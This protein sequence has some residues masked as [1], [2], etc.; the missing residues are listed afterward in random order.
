M[1]LKYTL[2]GKLDVWNDHGSMTLTPV[3][4]P[5]AFFA[6]EDARGEFVIVWIDT[7]EFNASRE[8]FQSSTRLWE[9]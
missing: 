3:R 5:G 8:K 7:E 9:F 2:R 6:D 1:K 4:L